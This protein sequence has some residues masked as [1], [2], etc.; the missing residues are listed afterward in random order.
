[1]RIRTKILSLTGLSCV[2][3]LT[4]FL[5]NIFYQEGNAR[6][7]VEHELNT[8][9]QNNTKNVAQNVWSQLETL[10][11]VL[12]AEVKSGLNVSREVLQK[13]GA[14]TVSTTDSVE[15]DVTNQ[16]TNSTSKMRIPKLLIGGKWLGQNKSLEES[17]LVVDE[18]K[19]MIG[20]TTTIFQRVSERGDMLR[21]ATNVET[22]DRT[23]AIGT[24]IPAREPE[25]SENPVVKALLS[26]KTYYGR[27]FVVNAWYLTAYEPIFNESKQVIGAL[28]FGIRQEK[29]EALR[30][31]IKSTVLGKS[32]YIYVLDRK[33]NYIIGKD[34]TQDGTNAL[35]N[36]DASGKLY[37]QDVVNSGV[38]L[39]PGEIAYE[40][41]T[42]EDKGESSPSKKTVAIAFFA[43]WD[44]IVAAQAYEDD[45]KETQN[46]I[47]DS[48]KQMA[49]WGGIIGGLVTLAILI[50]AYIL[51]NKIAHPIVQLT[52][53]AEDI[54]CG[55]IDRVISIESKDE[56]GQLAEAFKRMQL[57]LV[58]LMQRTQR[59]R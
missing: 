16:F 51:S 1:M 13:K 29:T 41:Y 38:K 7:Q 12:L 2:L 18:V 17:S 49:I 48:V 58:K 11:D 42:T 6:K 59:N 30:K 24:Y 52:Q 31:G 39:K 37:I 45:F 34:N 15:W 40:Q 28:Y 54:S 8:I 25:G 10:N 19:E 50:A 35:K 55:N 3:L 14:I 56:T 46:K 21:V 4:A 36:V 53:A 27:A 5:V 57:S 32:G 20:G 23:R 22:L 9:I 47:R 33:G 43:P 44:W 26:G